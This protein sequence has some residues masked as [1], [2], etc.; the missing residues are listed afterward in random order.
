[1][2][3]EAAAAYGTG[4]VELVH[5]DFLHFAD[6]MEDN[7]IDLVFTDPP[8]ELV[9]GGMNRGRLL[10]RGGEIFKN[11]GFQ[12][13]QIEFAA[14]IPEIYRILREERYFYVMSND[15]NLFRINECRQKQ[16]NI[17]KGGGAGA[18]VLAQIYMAISV[19]VPKDL[20]RIK[21]KVAL[22]LTKRQLICFGS[23]GAVGIPF[24]IFTKDFLGTQASSL[25]MVALMLP[26]FFLAM[27]EKHGF[28]A[29]KIL[30]LMVRQ[31][32]LVPGIRPY[33]S[34]K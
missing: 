28:P 26:F 34:E 21:T 14:W 24:Y 18:D 16:Q 20:S 10:Y 31:K 7:S 12:T 11:G 5:D 6:S 4:K 3:K 17:Q 25:M 13:K 15:R 22:N 29:E 9:S 27:Y 8:Y 30:Y 1:M 2:E 33:R 32:F 23:A 19:P